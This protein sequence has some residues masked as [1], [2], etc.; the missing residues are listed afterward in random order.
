MSAGS[1]V[2]VFGAG[3]I[4]LLA[5]LQFPA[6]GGRR[7]LRRRRGARTAG[8]GRRDRRRCPSTTGGATPVDQIRERRRASSLRRPRRGGHERSAPGGHR[9]GGFPGARPAL[10]RGAENPT[11]VVSDL[12]RL[13]NPAGHLGIAGVYAEKDLHPARGGTPRR[14]PSRALGDVLQQGHLG[15]LRP[16]PRPPLHHPAARS[17]R[18]PAAPGPELSSPTTATSTTQ[19]ALYQQF[20]QRANGVIKAVL[21]P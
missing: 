20:D 19:P 13:I 7:G 4:G 18:R 10:A 8:Q 21:C 17:R 12:A 11:Q 14:Q 3:A 15:Q 9:R 5:G 1:T 2:A 16:H 6:E